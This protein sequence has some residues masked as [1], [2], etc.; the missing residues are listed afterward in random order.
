MTPSASRRW[1]RFQQGVEDNPTRLP[2]SATERDAFSCSTA[3]IFRSIASTSR[4]FLYGPSSWGSK[5][6]NILA[7][8]VRVLALIDPLRG[9]RAG[10]RRRCGGILRQ[11]GLDLDS[12]RRAGRAANARAFN[13]GDRRAKA[14][15]VDL[16][17]TLRQRHHETAVKSISRPERIDGG[18][19]EHR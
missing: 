18:D 12:C 19:F 2:I 6:K 5:E 16:V 3:R 17:S 11:K 15:G 1:I 7:Q 8:A 14:H 13:S 10:P 4:F 9:G